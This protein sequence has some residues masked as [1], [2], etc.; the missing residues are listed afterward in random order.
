V[1]SGCVHSVY[2]DF[3]LESETPPIQSFRTVI[4]PSSSSSSSS[5]LLLLRLLGVSLSLPAFLL[6]LPLVSPFSLTS[7]S[8]SPPTSPPRASIAATSSAV[9][10]RPP[11][12]RGLRMA[13]L[14][15]DSCKYGLRP[16]EV[17][18][19]CSSSFWRAIRLFSIRWNCFAF[20]Y[21]GLS[22]TVPATGGAAS[23]LP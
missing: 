20:T 13:W 10:K 22:S 12:P 11:G 2:V 18:R 1:P 9:R 5:G 3:I 21:N 23:G 8:S 6:V 15:R 4:Y 16:L 7:F 14:C 17:R 19:S